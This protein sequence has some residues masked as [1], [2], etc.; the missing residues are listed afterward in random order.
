MFALCVVGKPL[1][2]LNLDMSNA[3]QDATCDIVKASEHAIA[4]HEV[5]LHKRDDM[6]YTITKHKSLQLPKQ[7][8]KNVTCC[9]AVQE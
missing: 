8:R 2:T 1:D 9:T 5:L 6:L 4:L 3:M 7:I